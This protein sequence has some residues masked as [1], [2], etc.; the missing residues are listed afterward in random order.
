MANGK[1]EDTEE[2]LRKFAKMSLDEL[3]I[4]AATSPGSAHA[5]TASVSINTRLAKAQLEAAS[6]QVKAAMA[7]RV[8]AWGT[9]GLI[10]ATLVVA[11]MTYLSLPVK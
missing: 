5:H 3:A 1:R 8:T 11:L 4:E 9:V 6:A 2:R 10:G 7:Q